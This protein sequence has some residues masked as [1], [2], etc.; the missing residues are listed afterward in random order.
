M[1]SKLPISSHAVFTSDTSV[2]EMYSL[3]FWAF[4][5]TL[6]VGLNQV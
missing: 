5:R 6:N 3:S 2:T 1:E 4:G